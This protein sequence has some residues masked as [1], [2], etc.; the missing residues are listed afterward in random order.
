MIVC[1]TKHI[2]VIQQSSYNK[3]I[4]INLG[5]LLISVYVLLK[6]Q[7]KRCKLVTPIDLVQMD[8]YVY[9]PV[10]A[11][12]SISLSLDYLQSVLIRHQST[13]IRM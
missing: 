9:K 2:Q 13:K 1:D 12:K 4:F 8:N 7:V 11:C 6:I 10:H 5:A 3:V